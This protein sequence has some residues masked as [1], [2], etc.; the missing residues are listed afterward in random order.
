TQAETV[1]VGDRLYTDIAAG[2]RAG[3]TAVCVLSGE[4][5]LEDLK[6]TPDRPDYVFQSVT[7]LTEALH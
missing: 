5:S 7:E 4:A 6:S 1:V 2:R 3:V